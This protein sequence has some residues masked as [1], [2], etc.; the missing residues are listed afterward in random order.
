MRLLKPMGSKLWDAWM[1]FAHKV[2]WINEHLLLGG[3]YLVVIGIY[4]IF[5]DISRWFRPKPNT[6]WRAFEHQPTTLEALEKQF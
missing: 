1:W 3:L 2:G 6:M 5:Y 4:A